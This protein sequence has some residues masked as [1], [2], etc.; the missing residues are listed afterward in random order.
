MLCRSAA[1]RELSAAGTHVTA[2]GLAALPADCALELL[3]LDQSDAAHDAAA[4][5]AA[6]QWSTSLKVISWAGGGGAVTDH[7]AAA[8]AVCTQ[9]RWVDLSG[10]AVTVDGVRELLRRQPHLAVE[11]AGCRSLPR[12]IRQAALAGGAALRRALGL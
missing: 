7:T 6:S 2:V 11:L 9:L 12:P 10:S 5:V 1:L 8:L 4:E 3:M